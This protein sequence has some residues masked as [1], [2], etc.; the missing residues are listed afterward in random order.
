MDK[1]ISK[2]PSASSQNI[3]KTILSNQQRLCHTSKD[4]T[5]FSGKRMRKQLSDKNTT[6]VNIKIDDDGVE[7]EV[8]SS[9]NRARMLT[10]Y[11][12]DT[13]F[14]SLTTDSF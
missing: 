8:D 14:D 10:L 3:M 11:S 2:A 9:S 13:H 4:T 6:G 1:S 5:S 7:E 12:I